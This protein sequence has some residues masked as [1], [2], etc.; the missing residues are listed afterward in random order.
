[1]PLDPEVQAIVDA[2]VKE[3]VAKAVAQ[4]KAPFDDALQGLAKSKA[5]ILSEKKALQ[6]AAK[7]PAAQAMRAA[8]KFLKGDG[9]RSIPK[10]AIRADEKSL[11]VNRSTVTDSAEYRRLKAVAEE[12]GLSMRIVDDMQAEVENVQP[13][14][15][16]FEHQGVTYLSS[17]YIE[18][19][20][21]GASGYA[22][23][24]ENNPT[25]RYHAFRDLN[26]LSEEVR[27]VHDAAVNDE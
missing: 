10:G 11:F 18:T 7:D 19:E 25:T 5:K 6:E 1:M 4:I 13:L 2:A 21:G 15:H 14:V 24:R 16:S 23:L 9:S 12:Q 8:D 20:L 22:R 3:A 17:E 26:G 27:Q